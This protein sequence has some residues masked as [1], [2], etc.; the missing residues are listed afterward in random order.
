MTENI[1][2]NSSFESCSQSWVF[3]TNGSGNFTTGTPAFEETRSGIV[4][5]NIVGTNTQFFQ[6][7]IKLDPNVEYELIFAARS[8]NGSDLSISLLKHTSPF[9]N[10]G[11]QAV[12]FDITSEFKLFYV[13]F[14]TINFNST[15]SDARLM[16]WFANFAQ[17]G[18]VYNI[19]AIILRKLSVEIPPPPSPVNI[20]RN[21]NFENGKTD[22][23][24]WASSSAQFNIANQGVNNSN[25]AE[26][27]IQ[28]PGNNIQLYQ[29]NIAL[30]SLTRYKLTFYAKAINANDFLVSVFKHISPYTNYGLWQRRFAITAELSQ[31][32]IEFT[33]TN[34]SQPSISD[35][36]LMFQFGSLANANGKY[37]FDNIELVEVSNQS[38]VSSVEDLSSN[39]QSQEQNDYVLLSNYPNPFNPDTKIVFRLKEK[40]YADFQ[41]YNILGEKVFEMN[42]TLYYAGENIINWSGQ[43]NSAGVYIGTLSFYSLEG[44]FIE[45]K[46]I[47]LNLLK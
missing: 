17:N 19:D 13:K 11:L 20:I 25:A 36:R 21:F 2:L 14:K 24:F 22:W 28:T 6:Q 45:R 35:A 42:R 34:F 41:I 7:C 1:I 16:F 30:K 43:K 39:E 40:G 26:I 18:T 10:Y 31:Y 37:Y 38:A 9:T 27:S 47:K 44:G 33:T 15:I 12:R 29:Y 23:N 3:Y 46:F 8:S 4:T 5:I 32:F